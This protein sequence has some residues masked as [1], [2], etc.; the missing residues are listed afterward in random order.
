MTWTTENT[1]IKYYRSDVG[2]HIYSVEVEDHL[3]IVY[4]AGDGGGIIHAEHCP[5][6]NK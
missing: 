4:G 1:K 6:K 5:C 3:Y 2:G